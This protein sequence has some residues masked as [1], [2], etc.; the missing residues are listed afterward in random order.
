MSSSGTRVAG[1]PQAPIR[2]TFNRFRKEVRNWYSVGLLACITLP[3]RFTPGGGFGGRLLR[4]RQVTFRMRDGTKI[5]CRLR[6]AGD[7]F[8]VYVHQD[9]ARYPIAWRQVSTVIDVGAT[10][11]SFTVWAA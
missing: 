8:S 9:Y 3:T 1:L 4:N 10:V 5:R 7:I 6:D 11:G 2:Q